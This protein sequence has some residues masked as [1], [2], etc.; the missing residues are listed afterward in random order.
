MPNATIS[1]YLNEKDYL[2]YV[3][4]KISINKSTREFFKKQI[5]DKKK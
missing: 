3:N 2:T 1:V 5:K 4:S